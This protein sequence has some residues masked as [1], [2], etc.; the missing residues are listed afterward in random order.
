VNEALHER[1][2]RLRERALI[3]SWEYRQRNHANG[4]WYR[5]RRVLVDAAQAWIIDDRDADRLESEGRIPLPIGSEFALPI[6]VF[7]L[8]E[9][10][11]AVAPS[12][13]RVPVRLCAELLQARNLALIAHE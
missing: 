13:R 5:F 6:R 1:V 4:A 7:L 10:Q 8:T 12:R 3:R 9:E 11:L 2:R